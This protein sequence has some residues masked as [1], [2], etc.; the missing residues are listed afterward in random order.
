[1]LDSEG[2]LCFPL[3]PDQVVDSIAVLD[4]GLDVVL[5][6]DIEFLVIS[7]EPQQ[8]LMPATRPC[9]DLQKP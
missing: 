2:I 5:I 6:P 9:R 1:M 7:E 8:R 4:Q 3:S